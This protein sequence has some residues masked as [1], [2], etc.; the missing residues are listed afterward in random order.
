MYRAISTEKLS[1]CPRNRNHGGRL[2]AHGRP[3]ARP[4]TEGFAAF[5]W[6]QSTRCG[7]RDRLP[8]CDEQ[9][10]ARHADYVHFNPV[11][12]CL[13]SRVKDWPY[14]SFHRM[15]RLGVYPSD[16]GGNPDDITGFGE[17]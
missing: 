16:W 6:R 13:V 8:L 14:S 5:A 9:D 12:H 7:V 17:R 1:Q 15:V 10:F 4:H 3:L 2:L 11:K